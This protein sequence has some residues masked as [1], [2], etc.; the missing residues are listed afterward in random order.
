M[1]QN[2]SSIFKGLR[3]ADFSWVI[4]A[5]MATQYLAIHGAEV[6]RIESRQRV[7]TLR[8]NMPMVNGIGPDHCPYYASYNMDK[9][10]ISLNL[11]HPRAVALAKRLV[12]T[13]DAV[14]ENFTPGT[15]P[16]LGLAYDK[17][18]EVRPNLV[19]LSMALGGQTGPESSYKG[20]G[21]VIQGAAGITHLTGWPDRDPVGT[22]VAYTDFLAAPVA[23]SVLISALLLQ[24]QTGRGQYIDLSQQ[25]ASLYA[26]D[27]A[28]LQQT[29]NGREA[30]RAGNRHP[31]AAP[32]GVYPCR[33]DDRWLAIAV[34]TDPQWQGLI[35]ALGA[36]AWSADRRFATFLG[37]K[38]NEDELDRLIGAWTKQRDARETMELLQRCGVPA[39]VVQDAADLT[40]DPQL[41]SRGHFLPLPHPKMGAF[42]MDSL[43]YRMD[44]IQPAPEQAAPCLGQDNAY[45]FHELLG[46]SGAEYADLEG[47]GV[48]E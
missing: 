17:L 35:D 34:F 9:R 29:V 5:P 21:T 38:A 42:P 2:Y 45:V 47:E 6:I 40:N 30:M 26:L 7:D 25:E 23:A 43:P 48:F 18:C 14:V 1:A 27:A 8:N 3:I 46:L 41:E 44:G 19:M 4:A 20:F 33:G 24:R 13:C 10:S 36:P 32:H 22:G 11:R 16:R 37:R 28:V 15:L 39:G 12:A 31:A